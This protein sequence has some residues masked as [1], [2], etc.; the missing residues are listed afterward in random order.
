M[1]D[2]ALENGNERQMEQADRLEALARRQ[3]QQRTG[4]F[5]DDE[6]GTDANEPATETEPSI[7]TESS[8]EADS[9]SEVELP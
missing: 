8:G 5:A 9:V 3:H 7:E 4:E 6:T 1:R 2:I